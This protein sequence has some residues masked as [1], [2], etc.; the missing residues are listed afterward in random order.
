[1]KQHTAAILRA[2]VGVVT[3]KKLSAF[4]PVVG[5]VTVPLKAFYMVRPFYWLQ[6]KTTSVRNL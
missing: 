5:V 1:M 4:L 2:L 6:F 3:N